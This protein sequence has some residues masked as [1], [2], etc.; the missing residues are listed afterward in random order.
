MALGSGTALGKL[1]EP[2]YGGDGKLTTL[3]VLDSPFAVAG[4]T[5][6]DFNGQPASA[7]M[8]FTDGGNRPRNRLPTVATKQSHSR[9][10]N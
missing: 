9:V 3:S 10:R 1:G 6:R 8:V 5:G 4:L 2:G 7:R